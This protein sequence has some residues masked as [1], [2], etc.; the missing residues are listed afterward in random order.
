MKSCYFNTL[1]QHTS[2]HFIIN[3]LEKPAE[4][5]LWRG[6]MSLWGQQQQSMVH[7]T[8]F[9]KLPRD[10]NNNAKNVFTFPLFILIFVIHSHA[11][12]CSPSSG[13]LGAPLHRLPQLSASWFQPWPDSYTNMHEEPIT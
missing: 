10:A 4:V 13:A 2:W 8:A 1:P 3:I 12:P 9:K 5:W 6:L 11:F 7:N